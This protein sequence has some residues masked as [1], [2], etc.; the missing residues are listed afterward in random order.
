MKTIQRL[1]LILTIN[2]YGLDLC[3]LKEFNS[4]ALLRFCG[5]LE[6]RQTP[7]AWYT[8]CP[9]IQKE[10]LSDERFFFY[11]DKLNA[12]DRPMKIIDTYIKVIRS[13]GETPLDYPVGQLISAIAMSS[14]A[15]EVFYDYLKNFSSLPTDK[16]Q[17]RIIIKNLFVYRESFSKPVDELSDVEKSLFMEPCLTDRRLIPA[18]ASEALTLLAQETGVL[19]LIQFFHKNNL[20]VDLC[21][22][23]YE[24]FRHAADKI[25]YNLKRLLKLLGCQD[26][27][28]LMKRWMENNASVYD[29]NVLC[30]KIKNLDDDQY[31][32]V[33]YSRSGY[34]NLIYDGRIDNISLLDFPDHKEDILVYAITNKKRGFIRLVKENYETFFNLSFSSILFRREFYTKYIN[35]NS[36]TISNLLDCEKMDGGKMLFNALES[37]RTYTF[38]E[39]QALYGLPIQYFKLYAGLDIPRVDDRLI[40]LKQLSK[41]KLLSSVTNDEHIE[42]LAEAF[43]QKPLSNWRE[44]EFAHIDGLK[45]KDAI[46]LLIRATEVERLIPQMKTRTDVSLVVRNWNNAQNYSTIEEMKNELINIDP[47]WSE[48]VRKMGF[49]DEFLMNNQE[50]I[51]GF[52]CRDGAEIAKT[53][54]NNLTSDKQRKAMKYIV[55]AELMGEFSKLKYY[56]DDLRKEIEYPI[57][58]TQKSIWAENTKLSKEDIIVRE[59]DDFYNTML[60]GTTPQRTCLSYIDGQYNECLLSSFDSNKKVIYAYMGDTIVSRAIVRLTKGRF[61]NPEK[62]KIDGIAT[63]LSFVDLEKQNAPEAKK[64]DEGDKERLVIFLER[65]Y[66]AGISDE[67]AQNIKRIY[68]ELM[69]KKA[70]L[71]GAMLVISSSYAKTLQSNFTRTLFH[72]YI[73]KSK[74]GAQYLDSLNGSAHV[75]DEGSYKVND[76]FIRNEDLLNG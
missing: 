13:H 12:F 49:S 75:S 59:C 44:Q 15:N 37:S 31:E 17:K 62:S 74:G 71:M 26:F 24:T 6:E 42:K 39:I 50:R 56:K 61:S 65:P 16:E 38:K 72:I 41:Q 58:N 40:A 1:N 19:E 47:A 5:N 11:L 4:D 35:L 64:E 28:A 46:N 68:A 21:M 20:S 7:Q 48:L 57:S 34:I 63:S 27:K 10:L 53:Y 2:K 36:L 29:L 33:L 52:L 3:L 55:K 43:S 23:N 60:I 45:H 18:E 8:D 67:T 76:F 30:K 25:L 51:I 54:Y 22:E 69:A 73:S 66:S 9:N 70:D 14:A 32:D